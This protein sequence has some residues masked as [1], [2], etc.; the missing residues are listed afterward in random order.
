MAVVFNQLILHQ[1]HKFK[2]KLKDK[3]A[4]SCILTSI[5]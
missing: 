5:S 4:N 3:L 1:T 2:D